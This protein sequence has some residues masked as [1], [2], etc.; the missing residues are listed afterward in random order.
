MRLFKVVLVILLL[1]AV[2]NW[3]RQGQRGF[4]ILESL[5]IIGGHDPSRFDLAAIAMIL[6]TLWGIARSRKTDDEGE[7]D[8]DVDDDDD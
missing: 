2:A 7:S 1:A 8:Y 4:S 3:M 6:V 5:P